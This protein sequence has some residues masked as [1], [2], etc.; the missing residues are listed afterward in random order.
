MKPGEEQQKERDK[1][2]G[3]QAGMKYSVRPKA[4]KTGGNCVPPYVL[5][6]AK[7]ISKSRHS[8]WSLSHSNFWSEKNMICNF[9]HFHNIMD[10]PK[11]KNNMKYYL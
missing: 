11:G 1:R 5:Q 4:E 7:R 10:A 8:F 6:G 3:S 9:F 2:W